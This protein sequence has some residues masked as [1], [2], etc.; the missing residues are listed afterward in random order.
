MGTPV[1]G[2]GAAPHDSHMEAPVERG[3]VRTIFESTERRVVSWLDPNAVGWYSLDDRSRKV[4][5]LRIFKSG[6]SPSIVTPN[7]HLLCNLRS[8]NQ[9]SVPSYAYGKEIDLSQDINSVR[10][11]ALRN[12]SINVKCISFYRPCVRR[13]PETQR[14]LRDGYVLPYRKWRPKRDSLQVFPRVERWWR[15]HRLLAVT[16]AHTQQRRAHWNQWSVP[17]CEYQNIGPGG[18]VRNV[19]GSDEIITLIIQSMAPAKRS[20]GIRPLLS[21][22]AH[23]RQAPCQV[24]SANAGIS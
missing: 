2:Q 10:K 14:W 20:C 16:T 12:V 24:L 18:R 19:S 21:N 22:S 4:D 15:P 9:E 13:I 3:P 6:I 1:H 17:P 23:E 7:H 11:D 8:S 5:T